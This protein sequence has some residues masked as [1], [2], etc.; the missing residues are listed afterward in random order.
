MDSVERM[1]EDSLRE[2]GI[3]NAEIAQNTN[4]AKM[5]ETITIRSEIGDKKIGYN[6]RISDRERAQVDDFQQFVAE[7]AARAAR[8]FKE[9]LTNRV[10]WGEK[11]V[12]F[13]LIRDNTA[14]CF[15]CGTEASL[16]DLNSFGCRMAETA[17]PNPVTKGYDD[18]PEHKKQMALHALLRIKCDPLCPNGLDNRKL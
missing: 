16:D 11:C 18:L 13:D 7:K 12:Q 2:E 14:T 9:E 5:E 15:R 3:Y 1:V 8:Y 17:V 6:I 10:E 4:P